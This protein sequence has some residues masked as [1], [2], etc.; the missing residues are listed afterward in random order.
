MYE[1]KILIIDDDTDVNNYLKIILKRDDFL[2]ETSTSMEEFF[3]KVLTFKP[4]LCLVDINIGDFA[5]VGFKIIEMIRRKIG[6]E[7]IIFVMSRRN[8][9]ND[10]ELALELGANDY[11]QKPIDNEILNSKINVFLDIHKDE[12]PFPF[13]AIPTGDQETEFSIPMKIYSLDEENIYLYS[14]NY[15]AKGSHIQVENNL[16]K[17]H[18]FM[19]KDVIINRELGGYLIK[20]EL[21]EIEH[22]DLFPLIRKIIISSES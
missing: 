12:K 18:Q 16:L 7:I 22:K 8:S 10:I 17:G 21:D 5:G 6:N 3:Q 15:I 13:F 1:R 9:D 19:I 4:H 2:V 14:K 20:L 11:I